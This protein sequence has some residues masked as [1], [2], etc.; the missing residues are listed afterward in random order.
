MEN[1]AKQLILRELDAEERLLWAGQ[2]RR[3]ICFR[4][5]D[6]YMIPF[7]LIWASFSI[8][9]EIQAFRENAPRFFRFW[10]IPFILAGAYLVAGR[11]VWDAWRRARTFYGV[12]DRH[13]LIVS[14]VGS[15]S[16]TMLAL[17]TLP[18]LTLYQDRV[19]DAELFN[20]LRHVGSDALALGFR[21]MRADN[22][23]IFIGKLFLP[24]RIG[25]QIGATVAAGVC[26]ELNDGHFA[27]PVGQFDCFTTGSI[28]PGAANQFRRGKIERLRLVLRPS[29][30]SH[31]QWSDGARR[32]ENGGDQ[33]E[34][35]DDFYPVCLHVSYLIRSWRNAKNKPMAFQQR[36]LVIPSVLALG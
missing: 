4:R 28:D 12:T 10:G 5:G 24:I 32:A 29:E 9:W 16:T 2:P 27:S 15:K 7:S 30:L 14:S 20:A 18:G 1:E 33:R 3:G 34:E 26:P 17:N 25:G 35:A 23:D 22:D 36:L 19:S 6:I 11:F 21:R 8:F 13:I 31:R